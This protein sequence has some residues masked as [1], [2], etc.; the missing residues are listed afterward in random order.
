MTAPQGVASSKVWAAVH[1][2]PG[3]DRVLVSA[4]SNAVQAYAQLKR[5]LDDSGVWGRDYTESK[6]GFIQDIVDGVRAA[7]GLAQI[8]VWTRRRRGTGRTTGDT[9]SLRRS[10]MPL[11]ERLIGGKCGSNQGGIVHDHNHPDPGQRRHSGS[12]TRR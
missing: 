4:L 9:E 1:L 11:V 12:C 2:F 5:G 6:T 3:Q 8:S 7:E 10:L